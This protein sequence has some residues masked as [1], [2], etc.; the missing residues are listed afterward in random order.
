MSFRLAS[1]FRY[2]KGIPRRCPDGSYVGDGGVITRA[3][4]GTFSSGPARQ[5]SD[6][7]LV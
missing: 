3:P 2:V 1:D 5:A 4:D 7:T 6:G